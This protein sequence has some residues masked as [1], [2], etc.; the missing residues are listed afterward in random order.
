VRKSNSELSETIIC[1]CEEVDEKQ[2]IQ[3]VHLGLKT[4]D[5]VKK[6]TRAGMGLC[7]GKICSKLVERI[8]TRETK[9]PPKHL[10]PPS[11][12]PPVRPLALG[13]FREHPKIFSN[14]GHKKGGKK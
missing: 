5:E 9:I 8:L 11:F 1:R 7:Q 2:I 10:I 13:E 3:A 14:F 6:A 4:L 12:R